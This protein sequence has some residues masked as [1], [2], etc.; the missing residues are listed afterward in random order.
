MMFFHAQW[1]EAFDEVIRNF[2]Q[3]NPTITVEF[4][5]APPGG[6]GYIGAA[7]AALA[8]GSGPDVMSVNWDLVR[9]WTT[10]GNLVDL[11]PEVNRDKAFA[12][13]LAAYHPKIQAL[14]KWENKQR[15]VGL[16]HDVVALYW[17]VSLFQQAQVRPLT[18]VHDKWTWNDLLDVARRLTKK[19]EHQYGFWGHS[20][21]GQTSFWPLIFANGGKVVSADGSSFAPMLEPAAVEAVQWLTDTAV[22]HGVAPLPDEIRAATGGTSAATLFTQGKLAMMI[23][24]SWTANTYITT[25]KDFEWDVAHLPHAP[26]TGKR[27]SVLHGTGFGI[28]V[29]GRSVD[30]SVLFAK[31]LATR[32]THKVYGSTG[33]IQSARMD[34]WD[35]FYA[36]PKPPKHRSVLKEAV[37]YAHEHPLTGQWGVITYDA[38]DPIEAALGR[39]FT[40]EVAVREGLQTGVTQADQELAK[41]VAEVKAATAKR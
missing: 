16:D 34:E 6:P 20:V 21:G 37:E 22:R 27:S 11:T 30:A 3:R 23:G 15:G 26:R 40:G 33:I 41:R 38:T 35:S 18:D 17:N 24:G 13:D 14:M 19:P 25:I 28:N 31:H 5:T 2:Q 9:T 4:G 10:R 12:K 1:K 32:E 29:D 7:T 39:V 8:A 36:S